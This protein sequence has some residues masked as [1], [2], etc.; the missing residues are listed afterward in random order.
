MSHTNGKALARLAIF[1]LGTTAL[2]LTLPADAAVISYP[3]GSNNASPIVLTDNSTQ[4]HV[5]SGE[6]ATQ[7]GPISDSGNGYGLTVDSYFGTLTYTAQNTYSGTTTIV[8][9]GTLQVGNGGTSGQLGP[10][11]V[12]LLR[13]ESYSGRCLLWRAARAYRLR[14]CK[15]LTA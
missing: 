11:A 5:N 10:G 12:A 2:M 7:S 15:N 13:R 6:T 8:G 1:C 14:S 3:N 9:S 4:L